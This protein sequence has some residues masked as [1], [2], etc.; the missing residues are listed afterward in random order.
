[1]H[2]KMTLHHQTSR[3]QGWWEGSHHKMVAVSVTH[4]HPVTGCRIKHGSIPLALQACYNYSPY[5]LIY[6]AY[7]LNIDLVVGPVIVCNVF[8]PNHAHK[9]WCKECIVRSLIIIFAKKNYWNAPKIWIIYIGFPKHLCTREVI[10][11]FDQKCLNKNS[12]NKLYS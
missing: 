8:L 2:H 5:C 12:S 11:L 10:F 9:T 4:F 1:M 7:I 6:Q 3:K